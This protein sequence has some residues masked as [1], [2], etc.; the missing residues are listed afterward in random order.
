MDEIKEKLGLKLVISFSPKCVISN[1]CQIL[2]L[3]VLIYIEHE[4]TIG[5]WS[6]GLTEVR[7]KI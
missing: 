4:G 6:N 3:Y 5:L 2:K 7:E 1:P